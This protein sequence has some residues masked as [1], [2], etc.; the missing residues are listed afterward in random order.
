MGI[1]G[2]NRGAV[3]LIE[4]VVWQLWCGN[5]GRN[6]GVGACG[7]N[8]DVGIYEWNRGVGV[9]P[10]ILVWQLFDGILFLR[11]VNGIVVREFHLISWCGTLG[12][13]CGVGC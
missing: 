6:R 5:L 4:V 11:I 10:G 8:R 12:M 3:F 2:W 13:N 7:W 1:S 9:S